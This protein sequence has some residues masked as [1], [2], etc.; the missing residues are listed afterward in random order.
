MKQLEFNKIVWGHFIH[1]MYCRE[2]GIVTFQSEKSMVKI[3]AEKYE[4]VCKIEQE[5]IDRGRHLCWHRPYTLYLD[6]SRKYFK[7]DLSKYKKNNTSS[8]YYETN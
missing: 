6:G 7:V 4:E 3:P 8:D 5:I 1:E 2:P